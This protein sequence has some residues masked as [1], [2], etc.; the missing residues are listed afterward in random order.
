[1]KKADRKFVYDYIKLTYDI[2]PDFPWAKT[3]NAAVFRHPNNQKWFALIMDVPKKS[4]GLNSNEIIEI[5]NLKCDPV[6]IDSLFLKNGFFPA[7][8]MNKEHWITVLLDNSVHSED[9][10]FLLNQSYDLTL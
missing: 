3:P 5:I 1:M 10:L 2:S 8:H 9:L 6:M 7:Y 4:L